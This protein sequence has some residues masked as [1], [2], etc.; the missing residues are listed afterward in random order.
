[1]TFERTALVVRKRVL[2]RT[3]WILARDQLG[4][5]AGDR[6]LRGA[7]LSTAQLEVPAGGDVVGQRRHPAMRGAHQPLVVELEDVPPDRHTRN[8]QLL[9]QLARQAEAVLA[10]ELQD[11]FASAVG[12]T[13]AERAACGV[14]AG[15]PSSVS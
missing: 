3:R 1:M 14:G 6:L 5:A 12:M 2:R 8:A 15:H 9:A 4:G 13:V 10:N 11:R 7:V